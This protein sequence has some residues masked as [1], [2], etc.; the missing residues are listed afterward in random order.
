M[1]E[2]AKREAFRLAMAFRTRGVAA[3]CDHMN[4]SFKAQFKFADRI[5]SR[6]V[7][8]LGDNEL[9]SGLWK[10]KDM[11]TGLE[12]TLPQDKLLAELAGKGCGE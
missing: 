10:Y 7:V 5:G 9:Q 8:I 12:V 6:Y 3:D 2:A 1:G 4:R 11:A